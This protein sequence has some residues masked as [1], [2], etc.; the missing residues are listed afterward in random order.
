MAVLPPAYMLLGIVEVAAPRRG[1]TRSRWPGC[2]SRSASGSGCRCWSAGSWRLP[3]DDRWQTMARAALRDDLHAVHAQLTAQVLAATSAGRLGPGA[4]RGVGGRRQRAS[5]P[6]PPRTLEEICADDEAD[7]ARLS[8]GLRVVRGCWPPAEPRPGRHSRGCPWTAPSAARGPRRRRRPVTPTQPPQPDRPAAPSDVAE[9]VR[10]TTGGERPRAAPSTRRSLARIAAQRSRAQ[11]VLAWCWPSEARAEADARDARRRGGRRA[12]ARCTA[13]RSR[14][15]RR[16]TS[17][18]RVTT[19]G[20]E[21]NTTP[22]AADAEVVRRLRAAGA[23][24]VG[25]TTMPEF[26]AFPF[27]ESSSR[28]ITRNPWD[29]TRTPGGSSG[30]TAAAVASGMVPVGD[31]A[32]TAAGRSGSPARAAGCSASSRSAAGSPPRRTRTCGGRSAPPGR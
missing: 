12:G 21:A 19:F 17:P 20:G 26:G 31:R 18:A 16:S 24:V 25:K 10:S 27:T 6:G 29:R 4:D 5:S 15:R 3:R 7:L 13:Y 28:G 2:T 1:S 14:S 9:T 30:G 22:A 11:R 32:A 8:V 23:V